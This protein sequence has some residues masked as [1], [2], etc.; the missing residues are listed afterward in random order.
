M[1]NTNSQITIHAVFAVKNRENFIT[2]N[3]RDDF[4]EVDDVSQK[5]LKQ[6][7]DKGIILLHGLPVLAKQLTSVTW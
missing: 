5:R 6:K 7:N 3:W 1:P 4:K 2:K